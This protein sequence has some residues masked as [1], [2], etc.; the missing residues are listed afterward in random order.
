MKNTMK[1]ISLLFAVM[2]MAIV[3]A[4]SVNAL[5]PTGQC[6][7]NVYWEF[8]ETT[9][10]LIISGEGDMWNYDMSD[11]DETNDSPF[12]NN[13]DIITVTIEDGVTSIGDFAFAYAL[14]LRSI[15]I[16]YSVTKIN[17]AAFISCINL[18]SVNIPDSITAI[19][20]GAFAACVSLRNINIPESVVY[21]GKEAFMG[22]WGIT[23]ITIPENA[24]NIGNK[25]FSDLDFLDNMYIKSMDVVLDEDFSGSTGNSI[26]AG[27]TYD[28]FV[29]LFKEY[30]ISGR[31]PEEY[32]KYI[33]R[34]NEKQWFGTIY[35]HSGSTAE[36]YAIKNGAK[37]VLT[38]FYEGEWTYD[39]DNSIKYR[40][41]IHCD[42]LEIEVF[43]PEI[44]TEPDAPEPDTPDT[45]NEPCTC[46]CHGNFIQRLIFKIT[47]FFQKLFGKNKVCA[48]GVA[49]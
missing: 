47:N 16:P 23:K 45:P 40:K 32:D 24:K 21:I 12:Y 8:D 13:H 9:S 49:H 19:D 26:I 44:P 31:A 6:G 33:V 43:I 39:Y 22:C 25:A 34:V 11:N 35:C 1:K 4:I 37:Y 20:D 42:E 27:I 28:E 10:K 29:L 14:Y 18:T 3:F 5:E 36:A 30:W 38:H 46:K 2:I 7:D 15:E 48:C 17:I 41:C